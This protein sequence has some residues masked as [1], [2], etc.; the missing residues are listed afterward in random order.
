[1]RCALAAPAP[2]PR[3]PVA[4]GIRQRD[5]ERVG[6]DRTVHFGSDCQIAEMM[7]GT[8]KPAKKVAVTTG[9]SGTSWA[10]ASS[11]SVTR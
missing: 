3:I 10:S 5:R 4:A 2:A 11:S 6:F 9:V 1:M 7:I 8:R